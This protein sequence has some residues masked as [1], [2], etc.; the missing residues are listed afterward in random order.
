MCLR[1][2]ACVFFVSDVEV[3]HNILNNVELRMSNHHLPRRI[4]PGVR[5]NREKARES[6]TK[7]WHQ[8]LRKL[9]TGLSH[10]HRCRLPDWR[11]HDYRNQRFKI[12]S[13]VS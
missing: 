2:I 3:R 13:D 11:P 6:Q 12:L 1:T 10:V 8:S 9:A 4:L 5:V 7:M